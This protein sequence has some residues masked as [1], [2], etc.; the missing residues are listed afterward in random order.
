VKRI[1]LAILLAVAAAAPIAGSAEGV[2]QGTSTQS[3]AHPG[4]M[5]SFQIAAAN[6]MAGKVIETMN[7]GGYT[8]VSVDTGAKVFWAAAPQFEVKVGEQVTV[9]GGSLMQNYHSKTLDRTFDE[10]YFV[11]AVKVE[12]RKG[13]EGSEGAGAPTGYGDARYGDV[14]AA[15]K[16]HGGAAKSAQA[17][18]IDL[19]GIAK[20]DGGKTIGEIFN[21]QSALGGQEVQI[22]AKVVKFSPNIMGTNWIHLQDATSGSSGEND[23]VV[24]SASSVDVG[25]TVLVRGKIILNKDYGFGYKY[26]VMIENAEVT[27]E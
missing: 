12:G 22:R 19:S 7:A 17:T 27:A 23:L 14:D 11:N 25:N 4:A 2:Q 8:Y 13:V 6:Q 9:P 5:Q 15:N 10:V 24:T 16:S 18:S 21:E 3:V 20:A 26:D 1:Y